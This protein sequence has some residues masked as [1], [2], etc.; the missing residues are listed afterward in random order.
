MESL[1][2]NFLIICLLPFVL[3]LFEN[4]RHVYSLQV[5]NNLTLLIYEKAIY[6]I[7]Y[8]TTLK[9]SCAL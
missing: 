3:L 8:H 4:K 9:G 5:S 6:Y 7:S 1:F 2:V